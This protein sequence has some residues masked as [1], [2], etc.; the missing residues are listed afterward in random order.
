MKGFLT[1][2]LIAFVLILAFFDIKAAA[3]E[4]WKFW[5]EVFK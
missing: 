3:I 1:F 2:L 4:D 5:G